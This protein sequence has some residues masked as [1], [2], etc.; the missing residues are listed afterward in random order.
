MRVTADRNRCSSQLRASTG[1]SRRSRVEAALSDRFRPVT[2]KDELVL[3]RLARRDELVPIKGLAKPKCSTFGKPGH[4]KL[5]CGRAPKPRNKSEAML[6][7]ID[8]KKKQGR[9]LNYDPEALAGTPQPRPGAREIC[10]WAQRIVAL[11]LYETI[12]NRGNRER[13]NSIRA[14]AGVIAKL[15]R[16]DVLANAER[17]VNNAKAPKRTTKQRSGPKPETIGGDNNKSRGGPPRRGRSSSSTRG[18]VS[19]SGAR[20]RRIAPGIERGLRPTAR[21]SR[22]PRGASSRPER[23]SSGVPPRDRRDGEGSDFGVGGLR[24]CRCR[25]SI[26]YAGRWLR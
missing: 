17:T 24:T 11:D 26:G 14:S 12:Q 1:R 23:M 3:S 22:Q 2:K 13:S 15:V 7:E 20:A 10:E 25:S 5:T 6:R 21:V 9:P 4:N 8:E 18:F 16:P 19:R